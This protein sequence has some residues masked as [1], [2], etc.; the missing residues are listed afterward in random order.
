MELDLL[1]ADGVF[2]LFL[3]NAYQSIN[4]F[5]PRCFFLLRL[6]VLEM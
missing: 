3:A 5:H 4:S 6:L 1:K 2:E